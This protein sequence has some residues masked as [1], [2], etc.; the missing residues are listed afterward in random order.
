M[1]PKVPVE[2]DHEAMKK[3][4]EIL[5][6]PTRARIYFEVLLHR[7]VSAKHLMQ[8]IAASRSTL[9]HHLSTLVKEGIL[10]FR[11]D[12]DKRPHKVYYPAEK[13]KAPVL[14][15]SGEDSG[16]LLPQRARW[17]EHT[18]MELQ[19]LVSVATT[20]AYKI[21]K[22][23]AQRNKSGKE[24]VAF[25]K[26]LPDVHST[27]VV[28]ILTKEEADIWWKMYLKFLKEFET[29]LKL[30]GDHRYVSF[31]GILPLVLEEPEEDPTF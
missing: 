4:M 23:I 22:M 26:A 31:S 17:F 13:F 29:R 28:H 5:S 9:S 19:T 10:E 30:G 12:V 24:P 1:I 2:Y 20:C 7:E 6:E 27:H 11:V 8:R 16:D 3:L 15:P 14:E 25:T 18:I 21:R